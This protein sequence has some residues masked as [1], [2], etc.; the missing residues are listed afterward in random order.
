MPEA[1]VLTLEALPPPVRDALQQLVLALLD[2]VRPA[3]MP[4]VVDF[5]HQVEGGRAG[6]VPA[7]A[8]RYP[9]S[10]TEV[11]V[12]DTLAAHAPLPAAALRPSSRFAAQIAAVCRP[13]EERG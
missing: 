11:L 10:A 8:A 3:V 9:R 12:L 2:T 4:A 13:E 7:D 1:P 6:P 5:M